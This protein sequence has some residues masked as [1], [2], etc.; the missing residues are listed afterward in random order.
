MAAQ[1]AA[2]VAAGEQLSASAVQ[3]NQ[4]EIKLVK[5]HSAL[6]ANRVRLDSAIVT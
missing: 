4:L 2:Y 3:L 5:S 1:E 6:A